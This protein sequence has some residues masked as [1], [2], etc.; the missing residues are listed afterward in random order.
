M[1]ALPPGTRIGTWVLGAPL[2]AGAQGQVYRARRGGRGPERAL[3]LLTRFP[4]P[5]TPEHARVARE[6]RLCAALRHPHLTRWIEL[7][8][9]GGEAALVSELV[10]GASLDRLL[11]AGR[12]EPA[13][14]QRIAL[15]VAHALAYLH[16]RGILH[17]DLKPSNVMIQPGDV[18][19]VVDFGLARGVDEAT[20]V[21]EAGQRKGTLAYMAPEIFRQQAIGPAADLYALGV[22][23]FEMLTG[24]PPFPVRNAAQIVVAHL[25]AP[26]PAPS[27]RLAALS[28]WWDKIVARL[29]AKSPDERYASAAGLASDLEALAPELASW[30]TR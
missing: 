12:L 22:L 29:L 7:V 16:A 5:G 13:R 11:A 2:G 4:E 30:A 24:A 17:R 8:S 23:L 27:S 18:P 6:V 10:P 25:S 19:R 21:S 14:V 3:K 26:P 20:I 1:K 15:G 9:A 28:G